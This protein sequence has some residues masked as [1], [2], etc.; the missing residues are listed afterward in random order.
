MPYKIEKRGDKWC[1][2]RRDTGEN[3]GCSDTEAMAQSHMNAMHAAEHK[4][5]SQEPL[6]VTRD[7]MEKLCPDC[8]QNMQSKGLTRVN[9]K[10]MPE[11]LMT[12]LC[13]AIGGDPGFFTKC[14]DGSYGP[15]DADQES[16]C[17]WLHH[18]CLGTWPT[19]K[20]RGMEKAF[21]GLLEPEDVN[22]IPLSIIN[23]KACANCR[24]YIA[25]APSRM[26]CYLVD[27]S[28]EDDE[29]ILATGYCDRW[30]APPAPPPD[31]VEAMA[32]MMSDVV[33]TLQEQTAPT[34]NDSV[35]TSEVMD[36]GKARKPL[37]DRIRQLFQRKPSDDAFS[38]FK[39]SDNEWHWHAIF[40]NNFED[41]EGEILTAK[42]HD[43]YIARLDMGLVPMPRLL[44]WHT[45]GTE[46]GETDAVWRNGHFV[47]AVG[48]FDATPEATKAIAFYQ[49]NASKIKMSHGFTAPEWAFDGKHYED[50]N[51][52]EITTLPPYAAANPYTS[53]EEL[54]HMTLTEEKRRHIEAVFG[55][56]KLAEIEAADDERSKALEDMK[57]AYKDF[58]DAT[59]P[60]PKPEQDK[61]LTS[62]Y[63][64]LATSQ[65]D[66]VKALTTIPTA[67]KALETKFETE[68]AAWQKELDALRAVVNAAP[69]RPTQDA[70]TT[71]KEGENLIDALPGDDREASFWGVPVKAVR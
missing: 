8:A 24:W 63:T 32:E 18:E 29:P 20:S 42:A 41:L 1:V 47:H 26:A 2:I 35:P 19:E 57:V 68:T 70:S 27:A 52:I 17:A 28:D 13:N 23:G 40:T 71:V 43:K 69:R 12:G 60:P 11:H 33:D 66:M 5:L 44:V 56:E 45:P 21:T 37:G 25:D 34:L 59:P 49:K 62:L 7:Q 16:F 30:E 61:A 54:Q 50:Y 65:A 48:H 3:K 64:D 15:P 36:M 67:L 14:V 31:A 39:G 6:W 10:Q 53:F 46:H 55:K 38:I 58:A 4:A 51:T 9:L 22:Y